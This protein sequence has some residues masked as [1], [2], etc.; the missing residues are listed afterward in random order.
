MTVELTET[1]PRGFRTA[2]ADSLP[3]V[4]VNL[5]RYIWRLVS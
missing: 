5:W 1:V 3:D 4:G 2:M